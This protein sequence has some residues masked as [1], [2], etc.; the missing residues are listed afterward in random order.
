MTYA[1]SVDYLYNIGNEMKTADFRL[2]RIVALLHELGDPQQ[3]FRSVHIAGTNGKGSTAAFI[4][5]GLRAAGYKT[6]LYTSPHLVE[7]TER[8]Q[9]NREPVT[10]DQFLA[11][12][13]VV[14]Q[15][16][17]R[18]MDAG[19][20]DR[21]TTYFETVTAMGFWL[22]REAQVDW[23]VIEVGLGGRLDATN[24]IRPDLAVITALAMDHMEYLGPTIECIA[25]EKAG[26]L[27]AHVPA[28]LAKQNE[29]SAEAIVREYA[30]KV[31]CPL[32]PAG[33]RFVA[34]VAADERGC[35]F[36]IEQGPT[37][38]SGLAGRYQVDNAVTA[39]LALEALAVPE[40][41]IARGLETARWAG[42]L[43][44][45]EGAPLVILDGAHNEH[46][47]RALVAYLDEFIRPRKIHLIF[48]AMRDKPAAAML[49]LLGPLA[50]EIIFTRPSNSRAQD[51][52][53]LAA[54]VQPD[55][56][57]VMESP[58]DALA[59]RSAVGP[60]DVVVVCG[61][62]FLIGDVRPHVI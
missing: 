33:E 12:F 29:P 58:I 2:D 14:H 47:A 1:E 7:P 54:L 26:I 56:T 16:N 25:A 6:G 3:S 62:L 57:R 18:L 48:G 37:F 28:I 59:V 43:E 20:I 51:P 11:A 19:T 4:E 61:S 31:G 9:I 23:G 22:L 34:V 13:Q 52:W 38:R 40:F 42:R 53:A 46:G 10:K 35:E 21:H 39:A 45:I 30:R 8:V 15:A 60:D 50:D 49:A 27:K 41:A 44:R 5:A 17:Q 24:V 32:T 55:R 36:R